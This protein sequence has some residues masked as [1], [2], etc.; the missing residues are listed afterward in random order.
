MIRQLFNARRRQILIDVNTQV[1]FF[2]ADGKVCTRNH[3]RVLEH[4][5]RVMA[6]ARHKHVPVISTCEVHPSNNGGSEFSYCIDGTRGQQKIGYTLMNSRV[7]FAADSK[8]DLP[9]DILRHYRQVILDKRTVDPFEEPRIERLLSEL[10]ASKFILIG[11]TAEGA[12]KAMALGL[13]QRRKNVTVVVD[14]VGSSNKKEAEL[15]IRKM[16]AKGANLIETRNL[17]G[18]S[19]LRVVGACGCKT[20]R[21]RL[22]KTMLELE[23]VN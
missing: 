6:W 5:R 14:A 13:L 18:N 1:D 10:R 7:S 3:R 17:A 19:C 22:K 9:S 11:A 8:T 21:N 15:A 2:I 12:V 4:I 20:C 23:N 16:K